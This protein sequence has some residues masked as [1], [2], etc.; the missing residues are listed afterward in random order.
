MEQPY[1]SANCR[2]IR[3]IAFARMYFVLLQRRVRDTADGRREFL[4]ILE[5]LARTTIRRMALGLS[6]L[7]NSQRK[8]LQNVG[9][10]ILR[11]CVSYY[12]IHL[13]SFFIMTNDEKYLLPKFLFPGSLIRSLIKL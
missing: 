9:I 5:A 1:V 11:D 7:G 13:S 12:L 2:D 8:F 6:T 10:T 3:C 4:R